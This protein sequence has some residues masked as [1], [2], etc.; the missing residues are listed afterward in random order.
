MN[1]RGRA[2]QRN[3]YVGSLLTVRGL[4]SEGHMRHWMMRILLQRSTDCARRSPT[5]QFGSRMGH[6]FPRFNDDGQLG[7]CRIAFFSCGARF[8][9]CC[10]DRCTS[11]FGDVDG[12]RARFW[13]NN[14]DE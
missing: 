5:H 2:L 7:C 1:G 9:M 12:K 8:T 10:F 3:R 4:I 11:S 13:I 6:H 14:D